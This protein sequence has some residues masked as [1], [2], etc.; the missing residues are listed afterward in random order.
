MPRRS[1]F[2]LIARTLVGY[3]V[4]VSLIFLVGIVSFYQARLREQRAGAAARINL[5]LQVSLENAMLKRDIPGL[6]EIV[7]RL[8]RQQG[9]GAV[10]IL[11]PVG[12]VR[13]ASDPALLDRTFDLARGDL[14]SDCVWDRKSELE[15]NEWLPASQNQPDPVLRSVKTVANRNECRQCH[16]DAST[17]PFNGIL[18]VDHDGQ[19]LRHKALL[20][21]LSLA[22]AGLLVVAGL[23]AGFYHALRRHVLV[24]VA[25]L[26]ETSQALASGDLNRRVRPTGEHELADLGRTFNGM[27][28]RL[29]ETLNQL[30]ERERFVQALVDALPDAVR[31]IDSDYRIVRTNQA[32]LAQLG[33]QGDAQIGRKC[34]QS[35]HCRA[36]PCISTLTTCP[37]MTLDPATSQIKFHARHLRKD[38]RELSVEVHAARVEIALN[39]TKHA[40]V[41]EVIRDLDAE[42]KISH[43]Q[44]LAELGL[45]ATGVAHEIRN[46][47]SSVAMLL[48]EVER[49]ADDGPGPATGLSTATTFRMI[50]HEVDRCIAITDSLLKL[51]I[52]SG[53]SAQLISLN[54]IITEIITLLRFQAD[55]IGVNILVEMEDGLRVFAA[56]SDLR[57]VM[58][59]LSLNAF[60]AMPDGGTL[61]VR[62]RRQDGTI[63]MTIADTGVGIAPEDQ[64]A[65]F[66]P[67]W[68]RRADGVNGTGLG[69]AI[70]QSVLKTMQGNITVNST[71]GN[72]A[73]FNILLPDPDRPPEADDVA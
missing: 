28:D 67:F 69:L 58:I 23:V 47:L 53:L 52:P 50:G 1:L 26:A 4:V 36:E 27:A 2:A 33:L 43:E 25:D 14:C 3:S 59:N 63:A 44:R 19:D 40:L 32:Y 17:H 7:E 72:G 34:Y 5:L 41:I 57:I 39:G 71:L 46:P 45:L 38:G 8:G 21:A 10:M 6:K 42:I 49:T 64:Q 73:A 31:V 9:I 24:P 35:S 20:G 18:V 37:L 65:I 70:C 16:G 62:A 55:Q 30:A 12:E 56:D 68:S 61:S 54:D 29:R 13:F 22:G 51:G 48:A 11:N 60:H 15:R 66:L